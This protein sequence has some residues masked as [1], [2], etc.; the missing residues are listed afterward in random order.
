[1]FVRDVQCI[2]LDADDNPIPETPD[3]KPRSRLSMSK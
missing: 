3:E 2:A 1:M